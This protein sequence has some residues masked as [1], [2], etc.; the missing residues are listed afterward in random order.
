MKLTLV[1]AVALAVLPLA[2]SYCNLKTYRV[3]AGM[4]IVR[5]SRRLARIA[6]PGSAACAALLL[7]AAL[8]APGRRVA[9]GAAPG[10]MCPPPPAAS[11]PVHAACVHGTPRA[12]VACIG[13]ATTRR[14]ASQRA[15]ERSRAAAPLAKLMPQP[16][17]HCRFPRCVCMRT[18]VPQE[19]GGHM[20]LRKGNLL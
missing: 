9:R 11:M 10:H 7:H 4:R 1:L 19:A 8:R 15:V 2:A 14:E 17:P 3:S 13:E 6:A 16:A 20:R 18:G 5:R 12:T